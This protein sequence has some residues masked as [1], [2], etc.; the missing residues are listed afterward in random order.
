MQL[1]KSENVLDRD[2]EW[3]ELARAWQRPGPELIIVLGRR[4]AGKSFLLKHFSEMVGGM[5][6]QATKRTEGDQLAK[7]SAIVG[8]QLGGLGSALSFPDWESF[9]DYLSSRAAAEPYLLILD[10]FTY[11]VEASPAL[12][13]ILQSYWDHRWPDTRLKLVLSGS[14]IT[15]MLRLEAAD[16]PLYGRRTVRLDIHPFDYLDAARFLAP[17]SP[18]DRMR[19][20]GI[21][22][23]LPGHV[24]VLDTTMSLEENVA[25]HLLQPTGRLL[26]DA[27]HLLDAFLSDARDHYSIIE[28]VANGENT[29]SGITS[30]TGLR[31]GSAQRAFQWLQNMR[32]LEKQV[33]ITEKNPSRSKRGLYLIADPYVAFWH[34]FI[35]PLV[36]SGSI[37]IAPAEQLWQEMVAPRLDEYMGPVFE[38][39]C[40]SFVRRGKRLPFAP[41]RVG[42]WWDRR[43]ENEIDVVAIGGKEHVLAGECKWGR[44]DGSDLQ[45]LRERA[46][47][48]LDEMGNPGAELHLAVFAGGAVDREVESEAAAGRVRLFDLTAL[49]AA[50]R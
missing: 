48:L 8:Q 29:Y 19:A 9:L 1:N 32:L 47:M 28:A 11:L 3:T 18:R 17:Y 27:Q 34:R 39:A 25:R 26:D 2:P 13:S 36:N 7:L 21:F 5:Y 40:R 46:T 45:S 12:P 49:Y 31:G 35:A 15:A 33:P 20:Y 6:Y 41:T 30:R 14:H 43:T 24:A 37:G 4:R 44:M 50:E 42:T 16:Q 38:S 10:E 22:G 23:G